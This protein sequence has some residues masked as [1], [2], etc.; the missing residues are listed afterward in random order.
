[1]EKSYERNGGI[2]HCVGYAVIGYTEKQG[3]DRYSDR[4]HCP[5]A[6]QL[7][8]TD[9][10]GIY[11][12]ASTG[13][14]RSCQE[15]RCEIL[16]KTEEI[17]APYKL[18]DFFIY[19]FVVAKLSPIEMAQRASCVF[20]GEFGSEYLKD[21]AHMLCRRFIT[22]QF[23]RSCAPEGAAL[24]HVHLNGSSRSVPSDAA[25]GVFNHYLGK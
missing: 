24:T 22:G 6:S 8:S 18:I 12:A 10:T 4:R 7:C 21:K 9:G 15:K 17:L 23:K 20:E 2:Y 25:M 3:S 19:C 14:N 11:K 13:G 16:Q 5:A 1:M